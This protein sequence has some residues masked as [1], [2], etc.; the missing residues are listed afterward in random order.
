MFDRDDTALVARLQALT[1]PDV[2]A[3]IALIAAPHSTAERGCT[4]CHTDRSG[5]RLCSG[6]MTECAFSD[7]AQRKYA[8]ELL[9]AARKLAWA[10]VAAVEANNALRKAKHPKGVVK[11]A[12]GNQLTLLG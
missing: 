9:K 11:L 5:D 7:R 8:I 3:I 6:H 10:Y 1:A 4:A 12:G 2:E